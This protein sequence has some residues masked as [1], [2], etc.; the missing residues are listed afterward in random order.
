MSTSR[1]QRHLERQWSRFIREFARMNLG[2]LEDVRDY[3]EMHAWNNACDVP[4]LSKARV[5]L[6]TAFSYI[7][8]VAYGEETFNCYRR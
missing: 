3:V 1:T 8:D 2:P 4:V 7:D 6:D 5:A